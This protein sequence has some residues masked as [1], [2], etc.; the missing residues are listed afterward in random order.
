MVEDSSLLLGSGAGVRIC[1]ATPPVEDSVSLAAYRDTIFVTDGSCDG[2]S[3]ADGNEIDGTFRLSHMNHVTAA[4]PYD[5]S[6]N[7][8]E[9][10]I[11]SLP[12]VGNVAVTRSGPTPEQGYNWTIVF[13]SNPGA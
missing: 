11:E 5:A 7:Q 13:V 9:V 4:I 8:M 6:E 1:V 3:P 2:D 12:S 10:A